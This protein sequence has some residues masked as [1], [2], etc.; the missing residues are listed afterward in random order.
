MQVRF[1]DMSGLINRFLVFGLSFVVA[2]Y[3]IATLA[4]E[5]EYSRND[6]ST[7]YGYLYLGDNARDLNSSKLESVDYRGSGPLEWGIGIGQYLTSSISVE[8]AF[9]YWGERYNRLG[10]AILPGTKNNVI[11]IGGVGLSVSALYNYTSNP[12]H[13]YV[14]VG[15]GYFHTGVLITVPTSGLL[16]DISAPSNQLLPE[17]H[18]VIGIN[19]RISD[20]HKLGLE[21]RHRNIDANFGVYTNGEVNAGGTY[22]L[23]M[24]RSSD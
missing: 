11:Q 6:L 22:I 9:E 14:G 18:A 23:L 21:I 10:G 15:L 1:I 19:Y 4:S 13:S 5:A 16:T 24:Y 7:S 17:Q 2:L 8:G 20:G 3:S 12:F